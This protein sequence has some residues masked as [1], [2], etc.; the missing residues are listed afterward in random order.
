MLI[1]RSA[2]VVAIHKEDP[3][4]WE[5]NGKTGVTHSAKL[6]CVGTRGDVAVIKL[7]AKTAEDLEKKI[8][9]YPAGKAADVIVLDVLPMFRPGERKASGYEFTG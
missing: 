5:M 7:K 2:Q 8:A 4:P 3:K 9:L 6:S 1:F